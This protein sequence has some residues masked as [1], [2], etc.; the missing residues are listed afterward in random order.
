M[1]T[2][3]SIKTAFTF[4]DDEQKSLAHSFESISANP[5][6][7]YEAFRFQIGR[8]MTDDLIPQ[9]FMDFISDLPRWD[10]DADPVFVVDNIPV[11]D[12]PLLDF[13]DPV[14]DKRARKNS[15]YSESFLELFAQL[16][17]T[18]AI[19]YL[20]VNG[21]DVF[22]DI[23]PKQELQNTQSQKALTEI[24]FHKDLANHFVRPDQ[25]YMV[26]VRN[27]P[28]NKVYTSFTRNIDVLQEF[29]EEEIEILRS[30]EFATPYDDLTVKDGSLQLGEAPRHPVLSEVTN[31]RYFENRTVGVTERAQ[32]LI[33]RINEAL[34]S[35]K[36]RLFV[37]PGQFVATY[38]NHTIHAKEIIE[39]LSGES[40]KH[41]WIMKTVNVDNLAPHAKH[42]MPG[43]NYL[44][45]G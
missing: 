25:V 37:A 16:A 33:P 14:N 31:L 27:D 43:T 19:S 3:W 9:R 7:Q 13:S 15:F 6:R 18:P 30:H 12:V 41:R 22:Q 44:V 20:N 39:V 5:Y 10:R 45:M 11:D 8:L 40:L 24:Y 28:M 21:G 36:Q 35:N 42:F 34:H 1:T 29:T 38:N 2:T 17:A 26:G 4:T 32:A 23:H